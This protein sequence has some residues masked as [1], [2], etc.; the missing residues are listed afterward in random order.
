[1]GSHL[2]KLAWRRHPAKA[3]GHTVDHQRGPR[4]E[5]S[6]RLDIFPPGSPGQSHSQVCRA[7]MKPGRGPE[8]PGLSVPALAEG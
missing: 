7:C 1:M 3:Q 5:E 4:P 6:E 8:A 2:G